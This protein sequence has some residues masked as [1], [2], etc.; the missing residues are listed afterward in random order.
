MKKDLRKGERHERGTIVG[1]ANDGEV[2]TFDTAEE[3][4]KYMLRHYD[5]NIHVFVSAL[6]TSDEI[7]GC[8]YFRYGIDKE[9]T[10]GYDDALCEVEQLKEIE[11]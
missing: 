11:K 6:G 5:V 7:G 9:A 2:I 3:A 1:W 8:T 4:V 10:A